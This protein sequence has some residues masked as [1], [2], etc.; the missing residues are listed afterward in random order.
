ME[1]Y[2]WIVCP[3]CKKIMFPVKTRSG[4]IYSLSTHCIGC[5][6]KTDL[7]FEQYLEKNVNNEDIIFPCQERD[8]V[9]F[10][11]SKFP[12]NP[13]FGYDKFVNDRDKAIRIMDLHFRNLATFAPKAGGVTDNEEE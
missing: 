6:G 5:E 7:L 1:G 3:H 4:N 8:Y 12:F 10:C 2:N 11:M 9:V 13:S